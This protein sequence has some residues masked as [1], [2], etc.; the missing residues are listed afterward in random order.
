MSGAVAP[1]EPEL[2]YMRQHGGWC[3]CVLVCIDAKREERVQ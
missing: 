1:S 3:V 2:Q